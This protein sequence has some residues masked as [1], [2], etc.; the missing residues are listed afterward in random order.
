[1]RPTGATAAGVAPTMLDI[2]SD[3][4][5]LEPEEK[6]RF[7]RTMVAA[8]IL[9]GVAVAMAGYLLHRGAEQSDSDLKKDG[10]VAGS[11]AATTAR[12]DATTVAMSKDTGVLPDAA[13]DPDAAPDAPP[14]AMI[15]TIVEIDAMPAIVNSGSG[16]GSGA[17]TGSGA[18]DDIE[19][20]PNT[21]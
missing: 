4:L 5:V 14:D 2:S 12:D 11:N 3:A 7:W 21:A 18:N 17:P 20:D 19:L 13:I 9:I 10:Q 8:M 16:A 15:P 1:R 6:S